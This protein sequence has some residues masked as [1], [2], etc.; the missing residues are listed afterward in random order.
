MTRAIKFMRIPNN[1]LKAITL[2]ALIAIAA[3]MISNPA[4]ASRPIFMQFQFGMVGITRDQ[5]ARLNVLNGSREPI[6]VSFNFT[7]SA[8]RQIKQ[9][10][11]TIMPDHAAF[12]DL[13]PSGVDDAAGRLQIHATLEIGERSPGGA[14]RQIIPTLE[15][16]DTSTGKTHIAL[17]ACDGSV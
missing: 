6:Q 2:S 8:G 15:V 9:A 10:V 7:D 5:T 17:G 13:T 11:E 3:L 16:F 1:L 14:G 12:L 4:Q